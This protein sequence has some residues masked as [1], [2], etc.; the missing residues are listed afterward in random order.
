V[1]IDSNTLQKIEHFLNPAQWSHGSDDS[2]DPFFLCQHEDTKRLLKNELYTSL[3]QQLAVGLIP[4]GACSL[5]D[6]ID[7][8]AGKPFRMAQ[9]D[10]FRF[11]QLLLRISRSLK[12]NRGNL[13]AL[14]SGSDRET[15]LAKCASRC[16]ICKYSFSSE[17]IDLYFGLGGGTRR[18][19]FRFYD[20]MKPSRHSG[21][22]LE[23]EIDHI[24][25]ISFLGTDDIANLQLLCSHCNQVKREFE[26]VFERGQLLSR[27]SL[28]PHPFVTL[29]MMSRFGCEKCRSEG[30]VRELTVAAR[31]QRLPPVI[32]NLLVT[33]IDAAHDPESGTRWMECQKATE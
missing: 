12:T 28:L 3:A 31:D 21:L 13:K 8:L 25:P 24:Q 9:Q 4:I 14:L 1:Q 27:V 17:A 26:S 32:D 18:A 5:Q 10:L 22:D 23:I 33:C 15:L 20:R 6:I 30:V 7:V 11:A 19:R 16:S 2:V 29:K